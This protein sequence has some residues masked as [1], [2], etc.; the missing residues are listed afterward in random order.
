MTEDKVNI[1]TSNL[2][3]KIIKD[4]IDVLSQLKKESD[5]ISKDTCTYLGFQSENI[6]S[7]P[8]FYYFKDIM[9]NILNKKYEVFHIH[10]IDYE[11]GGYQE[12]HDHKRTE[13]HSFILYLN[14]CDTGYTVFE[15]SVRIKP[16]KN[17]L[18]VFGSDLKH[19]GEI[20]LTN[21][22]IAVG[23]MNIRI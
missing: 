3:E 12:E 1:E 14:D 2:D 16:E 5:G 21:K 13:T 4:F 17:K 9:E 18:V 11:E 15:K 19:S 7:Y 23:A 6:L 20:C 22:K 8:Q 10:L